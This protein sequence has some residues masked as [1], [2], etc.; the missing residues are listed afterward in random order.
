MIIYQ[1]DL[2]GWF[3]S[4]S[5]QRLFFHLTQAVNERFAWLPRSKCKYLTVRIDMRTGDF[6]LLDGYGEVLTKEDIETVLHGSKII[7]FN[8]RD[9]TLK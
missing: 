9:S 2:N 1:N 6:L 3:N 5:L 7:P 8:L 4:G